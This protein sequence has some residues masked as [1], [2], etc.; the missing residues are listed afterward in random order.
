M[1][2]IIIGY[3]AFLLIYAV[4]S[5][6]AFYHC[7]EYGYAGDATKFMMSL[8]VLISAGIIVGTFFLIFTI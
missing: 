8:Y 1:A 6:A 4:F 2:G 5:M 3:C 7:L